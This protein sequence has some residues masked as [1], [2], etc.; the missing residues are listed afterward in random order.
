MHV[1][2]FIINI[3]TEDPERM[4]DFYENVLGLPKNREVG[5]GA[6]S[7][8]G[9]TIIF[10]T[11]SETKGPNKEPSRFLINL[12]V[13]DLAAEQQRLEAQGVRFVR[14]AGREFWGGVISTFT[15]PDGNYLQLIEFKPDG[16]GADT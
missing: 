15:D 9:A 16:G 7:A 13:D 2:S 4:M 10:D 3:T 5:E 12:F 6:V 11:H 14:S 8:A 1:T